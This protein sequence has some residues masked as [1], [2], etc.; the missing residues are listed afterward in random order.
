M[1]DIFSFLFPSFCIGCG[2]LGN[3][4]CP[5]CRSLLKTNKRHNCFYCEK[6]SAL[7]LTHVGCRKKGCVDGCGSIYRYDRLFKKIIIDSKYKS[8]HLILGDLLKQDEILLYKTIWKWKNL[9]DLVIAPVPLNAKRQ[10]ERGFNQSEIIAKH[11]S[12]RTGVPYKELLLREKDTPHLAR[13]KTPNERKRAIRHAFRYMG[14]SA[15][16][17]VL[18]I[19][20]VI[21]T[22]ATIGECSRVL[23]GVGVKNV[24][25]FSLAK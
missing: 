15:P 7:G 9:F 14:R 3:Y 8:A 18:L 20:D 21:T 12:S 2:A 13:M 6:R 5:T 19:D 23:K 17:S 22:G 25:A 24:L 11:I 1:C 10:D 16:H 4:F